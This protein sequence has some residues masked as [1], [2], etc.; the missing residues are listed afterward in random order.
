MQHLTSPAH[1]PFLHR[2][3]LPDSSSTDKLAQD[4]LRSPGKEKLKVLGEQRRLEARQPVIPPIDSSSVS[5]SQSASVKPMNKLKTTKSLESNPAERLF[6]QFWEGYNTRD[7]ERIHGLCLPN[8]HMW[9]SA[10]DE[11]LRGL[12]AVEA[13]LKDDWKKSEKGSINIAHRILSTSRDP[14]WAA[15]LCTATFWIKNEK[16]GLDEHI[17]KNYRCTVNIEK[18]NDG[19]WK[20]AHIHGSLPD[21]RTL[22]NLSTPEVRSKL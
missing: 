19:A 7:L 5:S 10:E 15:A 13:Q 3:Q 9:G 8:I 22:E 12:P 2:V 4:G 16:G 18:D 20:I 11:D 1:T 21:A 14:Q 17:L 6:Q